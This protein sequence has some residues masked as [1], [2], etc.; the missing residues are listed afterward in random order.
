MLTNA[1]DKYKLTIFL[2]TQRDFFVDGRFIILF[3]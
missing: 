3:Y 1:Y 2:F